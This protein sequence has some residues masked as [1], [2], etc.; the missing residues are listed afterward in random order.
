M[1][2]ALHVT[3]PKATIHTIYAGGLG[4]GAV[5]TIADEDVHCATYKAAGKR[6]VKLL[7]SN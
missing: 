2:F 1:A 3:A 7:Y 5:V 6:G 4:E